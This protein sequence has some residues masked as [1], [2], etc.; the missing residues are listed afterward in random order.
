MSTATGGTVADDHKVTNTV[1]MTLVRI[2]PGSFMMGTTDPEEA[3]FELPD[4]GK[5]GIDD[6]LPAHEVRITRT[7]LIGATEV[8]QAQWLAVMDSRPGPASH[9]QRKDWEQL[10]VVSISWDRVQDFIGAINHLDTRYHYRL[11]TEAEWEYAARAGREG[12]RPFPLEELA[13][14]AWYIGNSADQPQPVATRK[15]NDWGLYDTLGNAWEW[16][17]DW[18][19]PDSYGD[20]AVSDPAGATTGRARV[21]RGGSYHCPAHLVRPGYRAADA[22]DK[23]YSV[24]GFRLVAESRSADTVPMPRTDIPKP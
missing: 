21:R 4:P 17:A 18:Y 1:G 22:P 9:W 5:G 11:P 24:L 20:N 3:L 23:H 8:T 13:D 14:H 12:L 2:D 15:A 7:L 10:P 16:V 19:S 6:E